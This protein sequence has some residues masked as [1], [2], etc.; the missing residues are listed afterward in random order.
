MATLYLLTLTISIMIVFGC[1]VPSHYLKQCLRITSRTIGNKARWYLNRDIIAFIP[2][3]FIKI[4]SVMSAILSWPQCGKGRA[5]VY[6]IDHD[7][8]THWGWVTHTCVGNLT[9]IG[10][11]DGLSPGR[12]QA[13]IWTNA[14]ILFIRPPGASFSEIFI[15]IHTFS[16][17]KMHLKMSSGKFRSF[18]LGLN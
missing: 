15:E 7:F 8:L 16:L 4:P 18:C 13:I 10:S 6:G 12:H 2:G 3:N 9:I 1:S 5:F 14:G 17:T 11:D